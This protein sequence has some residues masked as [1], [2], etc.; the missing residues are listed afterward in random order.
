MKCLLV[1]V[2]LASH[3]GIAQTIGQSRA[4]TIADRN[5]AADAKRNAASDAQR[6]QAEDT[7]R[8]AEARVAEQSRQ[9]EIG[10]FAPL[11]PWRLMGSKVVFARGPD[12]V[13]ISGKVLEVQD[14]GIRVEGKWRTPG[15]SRGELWQGEFFVSGFPRGIADNESLYYDL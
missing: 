12:W 7:Q 3:A 1:M 8:E 9:K 6:R 14:S 11:H 4:S 10:E 13:Q 15:D 5:A 2:L